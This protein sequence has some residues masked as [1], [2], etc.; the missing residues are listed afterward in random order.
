MTKSVH[1]VAADLGA[2]SGRL[3]VGSW[4]GRVCSLDELHRFPNNGIHVNG[5]LHWDASG[6]WSEIQRGLMLYRERFQA[7]PAAIGVDA[8]GVDFALLDRSGELLGNPFHYRD[9]RTD[10]I[11]ELAFEQIDERQLFQVTGVQTMQINTLFQLYSMVRNADPKLTA[12]ETLLMIP[13]LFHHFLCGERVVEH[14]E[15]TT[16]QMYSPTSG[17]AREVLDTL[18]IPTHILAAVVHPGTKLSP[19][20]DE[21]LR[22]I[23]FSNTFPVVAVASHDTASAVAAIPGMDENSAFISSGTWSLMGVELRGPIASDLAYSLGFTNEGGADG[24]ILL[25]KNLTGLWLLQECQ[26]QWSREGRHYS[27]SDISAMAASA[28]SFACVLDVDANDFRAPDNMHRAITAYCRRTMQPNPEAIGVV[29]RGCFESLA[30]KYRSVLESLEAVTARRLDT[31]RIVGGGCLNSLLCQMT[32]D[33][34]NR[35][36]V[37]GPAEASAFGNVMLQAI[38]T[39]HLSNIRAGRAA[40]AESTQCVTYFPQRTDVWDEAYARLDQTHMHA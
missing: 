24:S 38:A 6:I 18:E 2:S 35:T 29:A 26:R 33:A 13:D 11:P 23:G 9:A 8:W 20:R 34:C 19:V 30:L 1:F 31:I 25:I 21:V 5:S 28:P 22:D 36:V 16:T 37:S 15:A 12:A 3:M 14:T 7:P 39:G 17:W 4:N 10:G 32:A 27:W 40:I